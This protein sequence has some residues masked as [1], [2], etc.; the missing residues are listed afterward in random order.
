[1]K[2]G[3]G[4][5]QTGSLSLRTRVQGCPA[6]AV[7]AAPSPSRPP[8]CDFRRPGTWQSVQKRS[9]SPQSEVGA[10]TFLWLQ[11]QQR[12]PWSS[13]KA[14]PAALPQ[15]SDTADG[16]SLSRHLGLLLMPASPS[17]TW[18]YTGGAHT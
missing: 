13:A 4:A 2:G 6:P 14:S 10:S 5:G 1:M 15:A 17:G 12:P 18:V 8:A 7:P 16:T 3:V 11:R 9:R